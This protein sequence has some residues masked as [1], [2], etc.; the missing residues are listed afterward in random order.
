MKRY[1][2][3]G[4]FTADAG[5]EAK[6][7]FLP[8]TDSMEKNTVWGRLHVKMQL[9]AKG[10]CHVYVMAGNEKD[11]IER[12]LND[13]AE[14]EEK[15]AELFDTYGR[16][17]GTNSENMLLY[18]VQG[19]FLWIYIE[20]LCSGSGAVYDI[21]LENPGDEFMQMFPEVYREPGGFFQRYL[22]V[23]STLY[24]DM[25]RK[26]DG[27]A[28][29]LDE[30][31][32]DR[33]LVRLYMRWMGFD[34]AR[35]G[36]TEKEERALLG[37]L[38]WLNRRKGTKAAILKLC[39]IFMEEEPM[40]LLMEDREL[41]LAF[42]EAEPEKAKKLSNILRRFLPAGIRVRIICGQEPARCGGHFFLDINSSIDTLPAGALDTARQYGRSIII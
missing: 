15:K 32:A 7:I 26:I 17:A 11:D 35:L 16:K 23:L 27:S 4:R 12:L 13:R 14:P 36:L 10:L 20:I 31:S 25:Q 33:D 3:D 38:Y 24:R 39:A 18:E 1:S 9:P 21:F 42:R 22:S 29:L 41:Y 8:V 37:N 40:I 28:G 5:R 34:G 6:R 19:R 30:A 2:I